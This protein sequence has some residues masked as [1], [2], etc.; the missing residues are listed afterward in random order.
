MFFLTAALSRADRRRRPTAVVD[1]YE[2]V[3][4][5]CLTTG[6][7]VRGNRRPDGKWDVEETPD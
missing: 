1:T 5:R 7:V 6:N 2:D 4:A 3:I